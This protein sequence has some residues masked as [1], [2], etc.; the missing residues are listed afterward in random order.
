M[1]PSPAHGATAPV[2]QGVLII[3]TTL[4]QSDTPHSVGLLWASVQLVAE[5]ST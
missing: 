2:G 4:S 5:T 1:S 3:K